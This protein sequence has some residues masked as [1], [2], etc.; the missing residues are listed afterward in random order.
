MA[1]YDRRLWRVARIVRDRLQRRHEA[2]LMAW[3]R[4]GDGAQFAIQRHQR[5]QRRLQRSL[6]RGM[7]NAARRV[8]PQVLRNLAELVQALEQVHRQLAWAPAAVP[9][10]RELMGELA[11]IE[12]EFGKL[13]VDPVQPAIRVRTEPIELQGLHLGPF[14]IQLDLEHLAEPGGRG[15]YAVVALEPNP[16]V[17]DDRIV[18][19]HVSDERLCAGEAT[20]PIQRALESGRLC[21]FF[22]LIANVLRTY[23]PDSPY[24][25]I[26]QWH[27]EPCADCG[28]RV[29]DDNRYFCERCERDHCDECMGFC[30]QCETGICQGCLGTCQGC[31]E[32]VCNECVCRCAQCGEQFC[33]RCM[34]GALCAAC[35]EDLEQEEIDDDDPQATDQETVTQ[36]TAAERFDAGVAVASKVQQSGAPGT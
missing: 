22:L 35:T 5:L 16:A 31:E 4:C 8:R 20:T 21:D 9:G 36:A 18:H 11:A 25:P 24:V 6:H 32:N 34:D 23:N 17:G 14:E 3:E 29:H 7:H 33:P 28:Y 30:Q 12:A 15:A 10:M 26:D 19:P 2:A 13:E 1:R 27:G